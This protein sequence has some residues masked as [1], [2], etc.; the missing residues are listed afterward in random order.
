MKYSEIPI[1]HKSVIRN[2][3]HE[4]QHVKCYYCG[5]W[6]SDAPPE[7]IRDKEID[8]KLFPKNFLNYPVHIHHSHATDDII[9]L[10]HARCNAVL[11]MYH[12]E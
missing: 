2:Q 8:W 11:W 1:G 4:E 10:V 5:G 3:L 7:R 12:G 9:G 6:L